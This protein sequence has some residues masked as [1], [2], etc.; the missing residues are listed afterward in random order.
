GTSIK[1]IT[2]N[3]LLSKV[4]EVPE[5]KEQEVIGEFFRNLDSLITLH[6]REPIADEGA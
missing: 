3:E 1:G 5:Y 2:K 4:V 6:Q